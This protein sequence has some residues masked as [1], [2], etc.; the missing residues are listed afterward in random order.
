MLGGVHDRISD[1]LPCEGVNS[2]LVVRFEVGGELTSL[3]QLA[4]LVAL[5]DMALHCA[6]NASNVLRVDST[7]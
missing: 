7:V 3:Q 1:S 5:S 2:S 4:I 6:S